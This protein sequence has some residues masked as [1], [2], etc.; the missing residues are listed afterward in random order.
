MHDNLYVTFL[1]F[2]ET[3][4]KRCFLNRFFYFLWLYDSYEIMIRGE[5]HLHNVWVFVVV[6]VFFNTF[7]LLMIASALISFF[8]FFFF[9][10]NHSTQ[11][12]PQFDIFCII[13]ITQNFSYMILAYKMADWPLCRMQNVDRIEYDRTSNKTDGTKNILNFNI[14]RFKLMIY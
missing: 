5:E 2:I 3:A 13:V 14:R 7:W 12:F 9:L 11:Y 1:A 4:I 6:A 8:S 10:L